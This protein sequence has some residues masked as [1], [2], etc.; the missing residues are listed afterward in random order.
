MKNAFKGNWLVFGLGLVFW[1]VSIL[2]FYPGLTT[3]DSD[4]QIMQAVS[5]VY[6]DGHPPLVTYVWGLLLNFFRTESPAPIMIF[7]VTIYWISYILLLLSIP[8]TSKNIL[9]SIAFFV[10]NPF[11]INYIG[12]I[13]KDVFVFDMYMLVVSV[14]LFTFKR[15]VELPIFARCIL[16]TTVILV[17][18]GRWNI[19]FSGFAVVL[20]VQYCTTRTIDVLNRRNI[21]LLFFL[22]V[23]LYLAVQILIYITIKPIKSYPASMLFVYDLV[24]ISVESGKYLLPQ[25]LYYDIKSIEPCYD[26]QSW[27]RI[28]VSCMPL[29][30]E[31]RGSGQ[32]RSLFKPWIDSIFNF[33]LEYLRHR[34][35]YT[36]GE[37]YINRLIFTHDPTATTEKF[38]F[39]NVGVYRFMVWFYGV[40]L[41]SKL[42]LFFTNGFWM[43]ASFIS[44]LYFFI[45][46][47]RNDFGVAAFIV[48]LSGLLYS[49]PMIIISTGYDFRYVYWTIGAFFIAAFCHAASRIARMP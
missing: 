40:V 5:G 49:L 12:N 18:T 8:K 34:L 32:W 10:I 16:Y 42:Y 30:D 6:S 14:S 39:L 17:S 45:S 21:A 7:H 31:L 48:S 11:I 33:P 2:T 27:D 25:S 20:L 15:K 24:G 22:Y 23:C 35:N 3:P 44:T 4:N 28:W 37:F 43:V 26:Y 38:G 1:I 9:I 41:Q 36:E 29:L 13:W 47:N 46:R 19:F